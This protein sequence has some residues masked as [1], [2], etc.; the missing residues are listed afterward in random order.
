[1]TTAAR[2]PLF[3]FGERSTSLS[4][5]LPRALSAA[6]AAGLDVDL[7]PAAETEFTAWRCVLRR[8]GRRLAAGMGKGRSRTAKVGSLYEAL[9]HY[10]A[11]PS[12]QNPGEF[13]AVRSHGLL[14]GALTAEWS[15]SLLDQFPDAPIGCVRYAMLDG[16][17][18]ADVPAYL[19]L[20]AYPELRSEPL[21]ARIGDS[22]DYPGTPL[23]NYSVNN[24][25]GAGGDLTEA[26]V[27]GINE[28]VERDA[29]SLLLARQFLAPRPGPLTVVDPDTLPDDTALLLEQAEHQT[30][31][32]VHVLDMTTDLGI[33]SYFA[34]REPQ[35]PMSSRVRGMGTSLSREYAITRA[36]SEVVQTRLAANIAPPVD[37]RLN[38][39][40]DAL[41]P[42]PRLH[43]AFTGDF[44]GALR[45]AD[46]VPYS[47]TTAPENPA[48]HLARLLRLL[49]ERGYPV[50]RRTVVDNG[51]LAVVSM[52]VPG[53]ER[54]FLVSE[55]HLVVPG[56]RGLAALS[57]AR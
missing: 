35:T 11:L 37:L 57:R 56:R 12:V 18:T 24:G 4:D 32:R 15:V 33:P 43:A 39:D 31:G 54:F 44:T 2:L 7:Q 5:A 10:Y 41:R 40:P 55:A 28:L 47:E 46:V 19:S 26:T 22:W 17:G 38:H 21:R 3:Q 36:L 9:E 51:G 16:G 23:A 29:L 1:M 13:F 25:W 20:P 53:L 27:H 52:V 34:Y 49:A 8:D 42:Y 48:G 14:T 30:G 50:L 6:D 45:Q